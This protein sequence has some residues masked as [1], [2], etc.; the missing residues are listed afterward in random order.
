MINHLKENSKCEF[1]NIFFIFCWDIIGIEEQKNL[2]VSIENLILK[3]FK[4]PNYYI[5]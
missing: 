4:E 2:T 3:S 5:T 1:Q